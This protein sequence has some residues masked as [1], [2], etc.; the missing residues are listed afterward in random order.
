MPAS[1]VSTST[2]VGELK[3]HQP[4]PLLCISLP[5]LLHVEAAIQK[6]I[7]SYLEIE[8]S[9]NCMNQIDPM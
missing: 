9:E 3:A 4:M 1:E 6:A 5:H 2:F 7:W 8:H